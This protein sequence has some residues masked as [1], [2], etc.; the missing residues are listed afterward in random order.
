MLIQIVK[1]FSLFLSFYL[2]ILVAKII[3]IKIPTR[4][5]HIS[6]I[7][8]IVLSVSFA[9]LSTA[10]KTLILGAVGRFNLVIFLMWTAIEVV[11]IRILFLPSK[12]SLFHFNFDYSPDW[13]LKNKLILLFLFL[14]QIFLFFR[15]YEWVF[16]GRDPGSYINLSVYIAREGSILIKDKIPPKFLKPENY[17][18]FYLPGRKYENTDISLYPRGHAPAFYLINMERGIIKP[19][20][21][22]L[23][24]SFIA[25]LYSLGGLKLSLFATPILMLISAWIVFILVKK[26]INLEAGLLVLSF[27]SFNFATVWYARYPNSEVL[28]LFLVI[29]GSYLFSLTAEMK[30]P[31]PLLLALS[32]FCLGAGIL[33]RVD[34]IFASII[35]FLVLIIYLLGRFI[36]FQKID[37]NH[38]ILLVSFCCINIVG[39]VIALWLST[40]Y[41]V[42]LLDDSVKLWR[43]LK[44]I[45]MIKK[46]WWGLAF[47]FLC[48]MG[49]LTLLARS[50]RWLATRLPK[51]NFLKGSLSLFF[52]FLNSF[53]IML[54][55]FRLTCYPVFLDDTTNILKLG[56]YLGPWVVL[57]GFIMLPLFIKRGIA[58]C[59]LFILGEFYFVFYV[60]Q[61]RIHPDHPW[62][63][64]RF[65]PIVFPTLIISFSLFLENLT[66]KQAYFKKILVT[67]TLFYFILTVKN[68]IPFRFYQ[69]AINYLNGLSLKVGENLVFVTHHEV[70]RNRIRTPLFYIYGKDVVILRD[71]TGNSKCFKAQKD[72]ILQF[73]RK[74]KRILIFSNESSEYLRKLVEPPLSLE[75]ISKEVV[76][77]YEWPRLK[78]RLALF[79][80]RKINRFRFNIYKVSGGN[81]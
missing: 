12:K 4:K 81:F 50:R 66:K 17:R 24:P 47:V 55:L 27:F 29:L 48:L 16:G 72:V 44:I 22:Y 25:F 37:L 77:L 8:F 5:R 2:G 78:D 69:G 76:P 30:S 67:V 58:P 74:G 61:A 21:L 57:I 19:Q 14:F 52:S 79:P 28:T 39:A 49:F 46:F 31:P 33:A 71:C 68:L 6:F 7:D 60:W 41:L 73:Q 53:I 59:L 35:I 64:R 26:W 1:F 63:A 42:D 10:F 54:F 38:F 3:F 23:Y 62:W 43:V 32:G 20:F 15:P 80:P 51:F 70:L 56:W 75:M 34:Y 11:I 45:D 40:P 18:Y 36:Y 13:D 9:V 65:L